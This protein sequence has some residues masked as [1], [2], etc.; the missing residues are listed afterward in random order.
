MIHCDTVIWQF[1]KFCVNR[2]KI[3]KKD[4]YQHYFH[5]VI[6]NYRAHGIVQVLSQHEMTTRNC[7]VPVIKEIKKANKAAFE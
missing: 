3:K 7:Y 6:L 1:G 2:Q 5:H 4:H